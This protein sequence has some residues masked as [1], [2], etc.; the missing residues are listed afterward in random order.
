M[1]QYRVN[2]LNPLLKKHVLIVVLFVVLFFQGIR[3]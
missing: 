2:A 1:H 3:L